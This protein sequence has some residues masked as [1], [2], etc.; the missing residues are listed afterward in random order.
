M[1]NV[2]IDTTNTV[3]DF[4]RSQF[5]ALINKDGKIFKALIANP[6]GTGTIETIFKDIEV[7]RDEWCNNSDFY[8]MSGEKLE[9]TMYF[10]SYLG[11]LYSESDESL[12]R[13]NEL[14]YY[15]GGDTLWGDVWNIR[16]MFQQFF[17][18][19]YV[20]IVNN[21][22][23][24]NENMLLDGDFELQN[25]SWMLDGCSYDEEARFSE[26]T[27]IKFYG[28]G[29]C[30]QTVS[31]V[32]NT[33]YF[34]HFFLEGKIVVQIK[35][36][37]GRYWD[38]YKGEFGDWI[39][40]TKSVEY[41]AKKW[42]AKNLYFI[43]DNDVS[44][45]TIMFIGLYNESAYLD[46]TR[47]FK[48]EAYSTFTLLAVFGG[49]YTVETL[50]FAPGKDDPVKRHLYND[51]FGHFSAGKDDKDKIQSAN[52]SFIEDA[53][54]ND[55]E[56]ILVNGKNDIGIIEPTNDFFLNE[57][58]PLAPW[59]SDEEGVTIDYTKMSYIEQSH[60]FGVEGSI[61][62]AKDVYTELLEMV[63]AGGIQ[64]Y[65]EILTRGLD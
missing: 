51:A 25:N 65:I 26:R 62:K 15:R 29:A 7:A 2:S 35:D 43:T 22:N 57:Q 9:K 19:E 21:T 46:Y 34:L 16:R 28:I 38:N 6:K 60:I 55:N 64:S 33:T 59:E 50:G 37:N 3:G 4:L 12:K 36:N 27:G 23:P 56:P 63:A 42:D 61:E 30:K 17:N 24:I 32:S 53:A 1:D 10:F 41:S 13:R 45:V 11:R 54:L 58:T 18:T 20:Y 47:L 40:T 14:L 8:E 48:K 5:S 49:I 52:V 31:V 39:N 44:N